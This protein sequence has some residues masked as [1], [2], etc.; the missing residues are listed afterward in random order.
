MCAAPQ[1][2]HVD[3]WSRHHAASV[4]RT[5]AAALGIGGQARELRTIKMK[6][7]LMIAGLYIDLGLH[8]DAVIND[9]VEPIADAGGGNRPVGAVRE[10]PIDLAFSGHG[11]IVTE[12]RP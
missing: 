12:F 10:Q 6:Q 4:V 3:R 2:A 8:L 1:S 5:D 11:D 9:N 7:R